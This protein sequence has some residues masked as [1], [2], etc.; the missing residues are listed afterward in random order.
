MPA[1]DTLIVDDLK[2]RLLNY[3]A[4]QTGYGEPVYLTAGGSAAVFKVQYAGT[5]RVF[6]AFNPEFLNGPRGE[7]ER[8]RLDVQRGLIGHDCPSIVQTYRIEEAEGTA[9]LEM[10]F[11]DSPQLT[12]VLRHIPD[13][14]IVPLITQLVEAVRFLEARHI[15][16]RDI[17]P[18]NIH[19]SSDFSSLKLLDL[20]VAREFDFV[21]QNDA[22]ITDHGNVR[23]F[24][25]TAQYSSPEYLF[26]LDEPTTKLWRGLNF[27]QVGAV[28][29][30][31][32]M[33]EPLFDAEVKLGNRWLVAKAVLTTPPSFSEPNR[34][35][36]PEL[37]AL[38]SRCLVK[39]LDTRLQLV[40][41]DDF[42][43]DGG[44]D[45]LS[46]LRGRL[47]KRQASAGV[48]AKATSGARLDFERAE[49]AKRFTDRVRNELIPICGTQLPLTTRSP[50]PGEASRFSFEFAVD[51]EVFV[52]CQVD[53]DWLSGLYQRSAN[54]AL[55]SNIMCKECSCEP[56]KSVLICAATILE[57]ED[58]SVVTLTSAIA[59]T[60]GKALDLIDGVEN[61]HE[62]CGLDLQ[63][64]VGK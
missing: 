51:G 22:V 9:F 20:G 21:D 1:L 33:K 13:S 63:L 12:D 37:K 40:G 59:N 24:L 29:H 53:I 38:A 50:A 44:Q 31:L 62:L 28:L 5:F 30:D 19:V 60:V 54:I 3:L 43:L 49:F 42:V 7:S 55:S 57:G 14:A 27:Y 52:S 58:E 47:A 18:E 17:K 61:S 41:W 26:R 15:V 6:K 39:D 64:G 25:A 48:Q 2:E 56:P 16:H 45:P 23:P 46:S 10:E 32:I 34:E 8:R 36:F 4:N 11:V 35:R